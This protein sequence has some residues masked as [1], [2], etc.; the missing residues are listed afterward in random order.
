[1][2][3]SFHGPQSLFAALI[4]PQP[5]VPDH[6]AKRTPKGLPRGARRSEEDSV[7][8]IATLSARWEGSW[9]CELPWGKLK[10]VLRRLDLASKCE[11]QI[12]TRTGAMHSAPR[13]VRCHVDD[14]SDVLV[15]M[16][17]TASQSK[18][19][20]V[21]VYLKSAVPRSPVYFN[22]LADRTGRRRHCLPVCR[23][24]L[25]G[26]TDSPPGFDRSCR[27]TPSMFKLFHLKKS[28]RLENNMRLES[29]S[30]LESSG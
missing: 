19:S 1:M 20:R 2:K 9:Y 7:N 16:R 11:N 22:D 29:S 27:A 3:A 18:A 26:G 15:A 28:G 6:V 17:F 4:E 30:S 23:G 10:P 8:S 12:R 24:L 13:H 14:V 21:Q 5:Y 25:H